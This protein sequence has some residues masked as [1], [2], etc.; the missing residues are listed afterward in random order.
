MSKWQ[1]HRLLGQAAEPGIV[2]KWAFTPILP[3]WRIVKMVILLP[4]AG[5]LQKGL[6]SMLTLMTA[7]ASC[8]FAELQRPLGEQNATKVLLTDFL[9]G[10]ATRAR[11]TPAEPV[12]FKSCGHALLPPD[13]KD[14]GCCLE[15]SEALGVGYYAD[16]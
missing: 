5:A 8:S 12:D 10:R 2:C 4:T 6:L 7:A 15:R 14:S 13:N 16:D 1:G 9:A 3:T 11:D